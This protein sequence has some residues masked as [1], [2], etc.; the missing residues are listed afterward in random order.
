VITYSASKKNT[1]TTICIDKESTDI[2]KAQP[3][4]TTTK[5]DAVQE[6]TITFNDKKTIT[7]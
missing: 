7:L 4:G 5:T 2:Y 1:N 6:E 3:K